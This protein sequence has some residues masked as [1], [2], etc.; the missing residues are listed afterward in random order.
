MNQRVTIETLPVDEDRRLTNDDKR[1]L[2]KQLAN[3]LESNDTLDNSRRA[4]ERQRLIEA[5]RKEVGVDKLQMRKIKL[6]AEVARIHQQ[7]QRL[8]FTGYNGDFGGGGISVDDTKAR[9]AHNRLSKALDVI[10]G[11]SAVVYSAKVLARLQ[12]CSS[13]GEALVVMNE[14]MGNGIMPTPKLIAN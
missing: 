7:I 8:G 4:H 11:Q 3:V 9:E 12:L 6:E 1:A 2:A 10:Q 14:V 13:V 5:Y